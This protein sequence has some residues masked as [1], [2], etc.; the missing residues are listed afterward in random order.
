MP[1]IMQ[2]IK[3]CP[4][5]SVYLFVI[6][7]KIEARKEKIIYINN[8]VTYINKRISIIKLAPFLVLWCEIKSDKSNLA[9]K[10]QM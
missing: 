2:C 7:V 8:I 10:Y 6:S 4:S 5:S 9:M 1:E 3:R